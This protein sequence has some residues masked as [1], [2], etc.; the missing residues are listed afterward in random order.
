M[1][2]HSHHNPE[3]HTGEI[4]KPHTKPIWRTFWILVI[5]TAIEFAFAF[6]MEA[7][8]LRNSIFIVLTIFKAFFIVAE[9]MHLKHEAKGLIWSILIP[10]AL[11]VWLV[12]ALISEGSYY[13][14]SVYNYFTQQ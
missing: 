1:A 5:L 6:L 4:A 10:M 14:D 3:P 11:L 8:M 2:A 9:F 13:Y 7:S 12:V